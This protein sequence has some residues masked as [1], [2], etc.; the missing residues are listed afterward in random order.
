MKHPAISLTGVFLLAFNN[1]TSAHSTGP[2]FQKR[3]EVDQSTQCLRAF[4]GKQLVLESRVSTGKHNSTPN[5]RYRVLE[6]QRMHYSKRYKSAPMPYS[7]QYSGHYFIHG[8]NHVPNHPASHGCIRVPMTN[9]NAAKQFF[10]W[11]ELGTLIEVSGHWIPPKKRPPGKS[12]TQPLNG[13]HH[14]GK[15]GEISA[16]GMKAPQIFGGSRKPAFDRITRSPPP[17]T[18]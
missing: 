2:P 9:E 6:K 11:V 8:F 3:V 7:V 4:E 12:M 15:H 10:E 1:N 5:G 18:P 14:I 13:C 17:S 16:R